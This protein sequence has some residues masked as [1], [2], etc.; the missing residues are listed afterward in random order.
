[1]KQLLMTPGPTPVPQDITKEMS[2]PIIHHRTPEYRQIFKKA[3][4][5]LKSVFKT[6]N[7]CL[8][9][10]SSGTGGM[11]ASV[12]NILSPGDKAIVIRG[13]KFGE[14]YYEICKSYGVDVIPIDIKWGTSPDPQSIKDLLSKN[15]SVK[16]VYT[17]L[18]ET[19]TATVYDIKSIGEAVRDSD[20]ALVV[21]AIS[22]LGADNLQTDAWGVDIAVGGSQ[23]A[24]M[25]PPGL[26]FCAISQKAWSMVKNSKL[27]RYYY[28]FNKY[29][30]AK[31]KDDTPFTPAITLTIGLKR[32]LEI[33]NKKGIDNIL[34]ECARMAQMIR[35]AAKG[36][37]LEVF[38]E[39]PSNAV[40]ALKMPE[41]VD[42]S[43]PIK[44]MKAKG[45][46]IAG[47]QG[48][49]KGKIIRIAHM[50]AIT[51]HDVEK[52]MAT[53]KEVLKEA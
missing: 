28:D 7:D 40:T 27:P 2:E 30:K 16:A 3:T 11:E 34:Q 21:D 51:K 22:G 47:G 15:A 50:G 32:S 52:T 36:L 31:E 25:L 53:L 17:E 24:L 20:A 43:A 29:K 4:S 18:C 33:I 13:G 26:S 5:D 41:G 44:A 6:G 14:R 1:M 42:A 10:T 23:K 12:V 9:F 49:L 46:T 8:I 38:S 35:D 19:S 37:G 45:I 48:E 39:S